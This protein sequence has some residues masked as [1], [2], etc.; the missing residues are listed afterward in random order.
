MSNIWYDYSKKR[1]RQVLGTIYRGD[2]EGNFGEVLNSFMAEYASYK[3]Y[4]DE[5][6]EVVERSGYGKHLY[7]D[8]V[9][10]KTV[11][12]DSIHLDWQDTY[13]DE[14]ELRVIGERAMDAGELAAYE[15][16]VELGKQREIEQL[17]KLK[18]K[19]PNV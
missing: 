12:F 9:E 13:D 15:A 3:N 19:Y 1:V 17:R 8:G 7:L 18:E 2:F 6:H 16:E 4:V 5:P 11:K 14:K 10:K